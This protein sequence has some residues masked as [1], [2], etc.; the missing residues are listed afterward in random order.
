MKF[1][2]LLFVSFF[3]TTLCADWIDLAAFETG[4]VKEVVRIHLDDYPEAFNPSLHFDGKHFTLTF[5]HLPD[6]RR[7]WH[8]VIGIVRLDRNLN[9]VSAPTILNT[10]QHQ[11]KTVPQSEDARLLEWN[12]RHYLVYNDNI[13]FVAAARDQRRDIYLSEISIDTLTLISTTKLLHDR[14]MET[15]LWEKNWTPF[16]WKGLLLM[17]YSIEPHEIIYPNL[18]Y[19]RAQTTYQTS[20]EI[21]WEWGS[22]RGGTPA[23]LV[24]G[25][26]LSF[27]HTALHTSSKAAPQEGKW[28]YFMGAYTFSAEPPFQITKVSP[29]PI[30]HS[31]FYKESD[32]KKRVIYP[33]GFVDMGDDLYVAYGKDDREMWIAI[34]DKEKLMQSLIPVEN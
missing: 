29:H 17:V 11:P 13:D 15:R 24:D 25:H 8:S 32:A 7:L 2:F 34:I 1:I 6:K 30:S 20:S 31:E 23:L 10:R 12:G 5:R 26:Y 14:Y 33:G 18:P 4:I 16:V 9:I 21:D 28:H 19:G 22:L 3:S 27:F